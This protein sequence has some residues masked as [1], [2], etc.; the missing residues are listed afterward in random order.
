MDIIK[1]SLV[2]SVGW[3]GIY[4]FLEYLAKKKKTTPKVE[5]ISNKISAIHASTTVALMGY[6]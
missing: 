2:S 5:I 3:L 1:C 6:N 4:K